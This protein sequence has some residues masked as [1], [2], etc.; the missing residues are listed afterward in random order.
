MLAD[1]KDIE[2]VHSSRVYTKA[3]ATGEAAEGD[4]VHLDGGPC[5][6]FILSAFLFLV[7][8][9]KVVLLCR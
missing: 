3:M 5:S 8:F 4:I 7:S 9:E 1:E 6:I 2:R